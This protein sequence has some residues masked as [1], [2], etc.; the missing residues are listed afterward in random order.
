MAITGV[1]EKHKEVFRTELG[2]Y[3]GPV[4]KIV[5]DPKETPRF[6]KA[7]SVPLMTSSRDLKVRE[8]YD[9]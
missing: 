9:Q 1:L 2:A 7:R 6:C 4:A 3:N 5:V 8:L